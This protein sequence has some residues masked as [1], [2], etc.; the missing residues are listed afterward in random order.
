MS[1]AAP[2]TKQRRS[3]KPRGRT[4]AR[5]I[6]RIFHNDRW[7]VRLGAVGLVLLLAMGL[8]VV[9]IWLV[10]P[11]WFPIRIR[12]SGLDYFQ[13]VALRRAALANARAG[14][15]DDSIAA[16]N[17]AIANNRGDLELYRGFLETLVSAPQAR[18]EHLPTAVSNGYTLL[19]LG[20]TNTADLELL[21]SYLR[22][23]DLF[24]SVASLLQPHAGDLSPTGVQLYA[25]ALFLT[26]NTA[27]YSAYFEKHQAVLTNDSSANLIHTAWNCFWG[28][29]GGFTS[30]R[31]ELADAR[32]NPALKKLACKLQLRVS[33][34]IPDIS[35]YR[36]A[37]DQLVELHADKVIDH[38]NLWLLLIDA[39][40]RREAADLARGFSHPP[41]T[42]EEA[43]RLVAALDSLGMTSYALEV[44]SRKLSESHGESQLWIA[45]AELLR[46]L[47]RWKELQE[48][49]VAMRGDRR[50][51]KRIGGYSYYLEGEADQNLGNA[52]AARVSFERSMDEP[53]PTP[54]LVLRAAVS[55]RG[56]G[57]PKF[58]SD[59]LQKNEDAFASRTDFWFEMARAAYDEK[60]PELLERATRRIY[61]LAPNNLMAINNY[62]A[63]LLANRTKADEA[64]KLTLRVVTEFP[65]RVDAQINHALALVLNRRIA[66]ASDILSRIKPE[67]LDNLEVNI[68][69]YVRFEIGVQTK[70]SAIAKSEAA[71]ID[72]HLLQPV[73]VRFMEDSLKQFEPASSE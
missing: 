30:A 68:L 10:T 60:D 7:F 73:Q 71:L 38:V 61:E 24:S 18:R 64:I 27:S 8:F 16:W 1:S 46:K 23:L 6:L 54:T 15:L 19:A 70:Q 53:F 44:I 62:A 12:I 55:L 21:S 48:L 58:S 47:S 42:T 37:L 41:E 33:R 65:E 51:G 59:L 17:R 50:L 14:K 57:Y 32:A 69:H 28:P 5:R 9:K 43:V 39:G 45:K 31:K 63:A 66:E 25:E 49:A 4:I 13:A 29:P 34:A 40:Q 22:R 67:G 26:D 11:P 72:R 20:R 36:L 52:E 2:A 56:M 35:G 3:R